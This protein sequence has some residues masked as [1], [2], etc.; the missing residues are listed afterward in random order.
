LRV[1]LR[2]ALAG[3][4]LF[5]AC[6][7]DPAPRS[8]PRS[9]SGARDTSTTEADRTRSDASSCA[10]AG[11][12]TRI[13]ID[14]AELSAPVRVSLVSPTSSDQPVGVLYLLHGAGTDESQW[15]AIGI[16]A[17]LDDIVASGQ[18][19]PFTIV[20]PDLPSGGDPALD[21]VAFFEEVVP[22][23]ERCLGGRQTAAHRA[24]GGISRGGSVALEVTADHG[25]AFAAVGGHSPAVADVDQ[26]SLAGRLASS[27]V[28]VWLDVGTE[29][30]LLTATQ[31]L[32]NTLSD[33]GSTPKLLLAPGSHDRAYWGAHLHDYLTWYAAAISS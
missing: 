7:S 5:A 2:L 31:E 27:G 3:L 4:A 28:P 25:D 12:I 11:D 22:A 30:A 29:D 21:A 18:S 19:R 16:Q 10:I 13:T 9:A 15:E 24:V 8:S 20:L 14:S 6:S 23:V 32:A 26:A 1:N 17:A 33:A